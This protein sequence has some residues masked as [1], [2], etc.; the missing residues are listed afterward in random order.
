MDYLVDHEETSKLVRNA[1][2]I[3]SVP[4]YDCGVP[5]TPTTELRRTGNYV[6]LP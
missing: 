3:A 2:Y 6:L 4:N 1:C 5:T